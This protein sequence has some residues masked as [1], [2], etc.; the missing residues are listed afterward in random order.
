MGELPANSNRKRADGDASD[1]KEFRRKKAKFCAA[2][3]HDQSLSPAARIVGWEI[4]DNLNARTGDAWPG[5][6][7]L[8]DKLSLGVRTIRR[9]TAAV[10]EGGYFRIEMVGRS[11][12]YVPCFEKAANLAAVDTGQIR[13]Q[14]RPNA[15]ALPAK[16]APLSSRENLFEPTL[17]SRKDPPHDD[18]DEADE[19]G[20][21]GTEQRSVLAD[22]DREMTEIARNG[23]AP[24]FV[25]E[26][27]KPWRAWS[28]YRQCNGLPG[29]FPTRQ[30]MIG[31]R[32]RTGWD[33]PTLWPP[34]YGRRHK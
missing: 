19:R 5:Q 16:K 17:A 14:H 23:G 33:A 32:W 13:P 7:Y 9:G 29:P 30:H 27:S 3:I 24:A 8:A 15:T 26:G 6:Q 11:R 2:I 20:K 4:G 1:Q 21:E 12:H 25:F 28:E 34:G 18:D 10:M 31:G 22:R